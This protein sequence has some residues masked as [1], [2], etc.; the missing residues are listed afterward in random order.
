M[1]IPF[2]LFF[3]AAW[4]YRPYPWQ[5]ELS[6]V[7]REEGWPTILDLPTGSGK[8]AVLD[9]ALH[10]LAVDGGRTA[11]RRIILVVDRR[12]IV[13]QAGQRAQHLLKALQN[14]ERA[15]SRALV[16]VLQEM[17]GALRRIVGEDAPLLHTEVLRGGTARQDAW[18]TYP[19]T[20]VLAASTV[21]QVGSRLFFRGYGVSDGMQPVHA[22]LLGCDTLLLLDEVHL[23]RPFAAVL[24]QLQRLRDQAG[25]SEIPRRFQVV[26]L[27][28]TP[29]HWMPNN[30]ASDHEGGQAGS[31]GGAGAPDHEFAGAHFELRDGDRANPRLARILGARKR[32]LLELVE[33]KTRSGEEL[34]RRTVAEHAARHARRMVKQGRKSVAVVVN[35]VDTA[36]RVW[37]LLQDDAIDVELITGR[38]RPLDQESA[39]ARIAPRVIAGRA[40]DPEARP[41]VVVATQCIEAGAD[42]D[43]DALVTECAS[44]D[45]LRQRFGRLDRIGRLATPPLEDALPT[46]VQLDSFA[47]ERSAATDGEA[48]SSARAA[49][50]MRSDYLS[51][52]V[53]PVYEAALP[54]TW[55]WLTEIALNGEVDFGI[56]ALQ[57]HVKAAGKRVGEMLAPH[58]HAPVL[59]PAY[60]D[61]WTQTNPKPHADPDVSLFL[62]GIPEDARAALPDVQVVW[63]SDLT[64]EDLAP[65]PPEASSEKRPDPVV[66]LKKLREHLAI[67]P[68]GSLEAMSLPV[69]TVQQWLSATDGQVQDDIA[70]VEGRAGPVAETPPHTRRVL[71]W[72]GGRRSEVIEASEIPPGSMVVVPESYGGIG[73][74]GTFD[75]A[76]QPQPDAEHTRAPVYDLGDVVQLRQRGNP[77]LRL[78]PRVLRPLAP[79]LDIAALL[80]DL[81]DDEVD[82]E[83]VLR[84]ALDA[85]RRNEHHHDPGWFT[86]MLAALSDRPKF[87]FSPQE[88]WVALGRRLAS[89]RRT[90][91]HASA[92]AN[93]GGSTSVFDPSPTGDADA[94]GE[95]FVGGVKARLADHLA[96]VE[97]LAERFARQLQLPQRVVASLKWAARL[98]DI[99]KADPRFQL[100]MHGGDEISARF[101]ESLAKS[102]IPWQNVVAR[103]EARRRA[104]YPEGQRHELVSLEMIEHATGIEARVQEDGG[105]WELVLHLVASHH[106]WCRPLAPAL[107][108]P[109]GGEDAVTFALDGIELSGSTEHGRDR[110]DSGVAARFWRLNLQY[111]WHELAYLEAIL[112]LADHRRSAREAEK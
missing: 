56:D 75:P 64:E 48:G 5:I 13:D 87:V 29:G 76:V 32:A 50:L 25:H 71:L 6:R 89:G 74:H 81:H 102:A 4:G 23:A 68:P 111:G 107:Q 52:V 58:R 95:S 15:G 2:E 60:L 34:K 41:I 42:Y 21:D 96:G 94:E 40:P 99:G 11:P 105:D 109:V 63:R 8:T 88:Q 100:W 66:M 1:S 55:H 24:A 53:D 14:A 3:E 82:P 103:M 72:R 46:E 18:A 73:V 19:H 43:F 83:S 80:P 47:G 93:S 77:T 35:R 12:V 22:G 70:D 36:R 104:R 101:G 67:V 45:A 78:D 10:H 30:L 108:L 86:E 92:P 65:M 16:S 57:P 84:D 106:G 97:E 9:V 31:T 61:Q 33:V 98:H 69:W 38:M 79:G 62:H 26:Q 20:P 85:L 112:R 90:T 37:S 54:A 17:R 91:L 110:L 27:S 59:L 7:V 39:I 49:I 44:L 51:S 28:A